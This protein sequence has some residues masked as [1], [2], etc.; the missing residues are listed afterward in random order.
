MII[1]VVLC[2]Y[3]IAFEI[4]TFPPFSELRKFILNSDVTYCVH[5]PCYYS[6]WSIT[7][8]LS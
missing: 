5:R 7:H 6:C 2:Y 3:E 4:A 8:F 1:S